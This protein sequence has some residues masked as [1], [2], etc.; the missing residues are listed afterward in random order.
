M[1]LEIQQVFEIQKKNAPYLARAN[2]EERLE[3]IRRIENY[4]QDEERL[5]DLY[6]AMYADLHKPETEVIATEVGVVQ[7]HI[8]HVKRNLHKWMK[9]T[10]VPTP[11]PLIGTRSHIRY[12]P[13]GVVLIIAPWNFPFNLTLVPL[14]YAIAAGN[15]AILKPSEMAANTSA[16]IS[17]MMYE[18]FDESE[19][20]VFEGNESVAQQLLDLPF[21][22][23]F[24]T[25]SPR[26][27]KKVMSRAAEHLSSVTLELGGKSP[28][29]VDE[30]A[31][32]KKIAKNLAWAKFINNGQACIAP[33][34]LIVHE[35]A[36]DGFVNEFGKA[37]EQLYDPSGEGIRN[38]S[39]YCRIINDHHYNRLLTLYNDACEKDARVLY[40]G[41]FDDS[42]LYI[43]PTLLENVSGDMKI[44]QEEIFGP[45]LPMITYRNRED[46]I[47][48]IEQNP[49]PLILYIASENQGNIDYFMDSIPSGSTLT[50]DY[51]LSYSNP[52]LPFGGINSS[53]IGKSLGFH[54]FVGFSNERAVMQRKWG[55]MGML[56][57]PY[58]ENIRKIFRTIY[59]WM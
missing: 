18:L 11:L 34:Y 28:A 38:S 55:S 44:M 40:G 1:C 2:A 9:D 13:K 47:P 56:Y 50:N 26:V 7:A 33:D 27:G 49:S 14:I 46:V 45:L 16:Y 54:G 58:S 57:P 51:M 53:G 32:V 52:H 41:D 8:N 15:A 23:V 17:L 43:A 5:S 35:S 48:V 36:R 39:D 20:A 25:G 59:R 19:V 30:T 31:N 42:D 21:N 22:H 37:I 29:I 10:K 6:K 12:E 3:R 24:F 4:L